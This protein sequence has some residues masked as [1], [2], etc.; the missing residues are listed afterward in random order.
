MCDMGPGPLFGQGSRLRG[1]RGCLSFLVK[2]EGRTFKS[3]SLSPQRLP[4]EPEP[5]PSERSEQRL[6]EAQTPCRFLQHLTRGLLLKIKKQN[7]HKPPN[8]PASKIRVSPEPK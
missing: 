7:C 4:S 8:K 1:E 3:S 6:S 2:R 5:R